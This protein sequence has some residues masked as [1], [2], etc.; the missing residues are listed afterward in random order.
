MK[1]KRH[2]SIASARLARG[3]CPGLVLLAARCPTAFDSRQTGSP[4]G[5][6]DDGGGGI[7]MIATTDCPEVTL[8]GFD[9]PPVCTADAVASGADVACFQ[10]CGGGTVYTVTQ[11]GNN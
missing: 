10:F 7:S 6:D 4:S 2:F 11:T 9:D 1:T 8:A 5:N 3:L